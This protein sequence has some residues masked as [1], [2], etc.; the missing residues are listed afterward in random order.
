[1]ES[2]SYRGTVYNDNFR[3]KVVSLHMY[4]VRYCG[5]QAIYRYPNIEMDVIG[6]LRPS[7]Q[8]AHEFQLPLP[9]IYRWKQEFLATTIWTEETLVALG[10]FNAGK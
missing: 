4:Y 5:Y 2:R 7:L 1:M 3:L 8:A 6:W 10:R 9:T